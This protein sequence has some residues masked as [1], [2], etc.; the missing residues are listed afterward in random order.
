M[1]D[2]KYLIGFE[3]RP[4]YIHERKG[5]F[6]AWINRAR[7]APASMMIGGGEGGQLWEVFGLIEFE[8]GHMEEVYPTRVRFADGGDFAC[9]AFRPVEE[10][11]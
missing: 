2:C 5:M 9:V 4:C 7:V 11:A 3:T 10:R 1:K 6:H 8:D